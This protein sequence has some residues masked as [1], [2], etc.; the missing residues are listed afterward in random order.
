MNPAEQNTSLAQYS[1]RAVLVLTALSAAGIALYNTFIWEPPTHQIALYEKAPMYR[2]TSATI[3]PNQIRIRIV[4]RNDR[5]GGISLENGRGRKTYGQVSNQQAMV[6][7]A[8]WLDFVEIP[9]SPGRNLVDPIEI[10]VFDHATRELLNVDHPRCGWRY[11]PQVPSVHLYGLGQELPDQ[12]DLWFRVHS[13]EPSDEVMTLKPTPGASIKLPGSADGTL[14]VNQ[15]QNGYRGWDSV[16]GFA[17]VAGDHHQDC[18]IEL[19]WMNVW[20]GKQLKYEVIAITNDG[21][22][23]S[24]DRF[25]IFNGSGKEPLH[26]PCR[27]DEVFRLE[28]RPDGGRHVF[29]FDGLKLPSINRSPQRTPFAK[30]PTA[31]VKVGGK[32]VPRSEIKEFHPLHVR[33]Q[34]TDGRVYSGSTGNSSYVQLLPK[35]QGPEDV[36][37]SFSLAWETRGLGELP[38]SFRVRRTGQTTWLPNTSLNQRGGFS[39]NNA[40]MNASAKTFQTPLKDIDAIEVQVLPASGN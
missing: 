32:P 21:Q 9:L 33:F 34:V 12:I 17:P 20:P 7:S 27:L 19:S 31:V 25:H 24:D 8:A 23:F 11:D 38:L 18:G 5:D 28:V 14:Q 35:P 29:F 37:K 10:R 2:G 26:F 30:P 13:Y 22:R 40:T 36:G 1:I 4:A 6:D 16:N 15:M 3:G 39:S